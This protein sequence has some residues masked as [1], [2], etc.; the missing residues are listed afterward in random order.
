M[1]KKIINIG[2]GESTGDG[3]SIRSAFSKINDNF[4]EVYNG[5]IVE[6]GAS[7]FSGDTPPEDAVDNQLWWNTED[8][9]LYIRYMNSWIEANTIG[10]M[11]DIGY[12]GSQGDIGPQGDIGYTG[13]AS[14]VAGYTGSKGDI[15]HTGSK[16]TIGFTGSRGST[17]Y[18]GSQG[19]IGDTGAQG[20]IGF[21]GS[22]GD[23]GY[24]G[25]RGSVGFTGSKGSTGY[26]GSQGVD[27]YVGSKGD[28]GETGA[29]GFTGSKGFTGS[30][31]VGY[32]GSA[33][34]ALGPVG[35]TGSQGVGYTGSMGP[36]GDVNVDSTPPNVGNLWWDPIGGN[37]YIKYGS[38]WIAAI[39][40]N[41]NL[42]YIPNNPANWN[43]PV[44]T[45]FGALDQ[46]AARLNALEN[47]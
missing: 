35:Y 17:G 27:G 24:N 44:N 38:Q 25:S 9:K 46:I 20:D 23:D 42:T 45:L 39:T 36:F 4:D 29:D 3:E 15:G 34:T 18:V 47:P 37:L 21:T 40:I 22:R 5:I 31:G 16:G 11:G 7:V 43:S 12:S 10:P 28:I 33:S 6:N 32:T 13:S 8:G 14:S 19:N 26:V 41:P 2:S 30:R 1:A